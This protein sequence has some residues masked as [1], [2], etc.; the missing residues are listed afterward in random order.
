MTIAELHGKLSPNRPNGCNDRMEDLL[1]SDVFSTMKYAGWQC[2]FL[3]WLKSSIDPINN[4]HTAAP[5]IPDDHLMSLILTKK[6]NF[7]HIT[8]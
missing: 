4:N 5:Q 3:D 8:A 7:N 1:T 2:G 6:I